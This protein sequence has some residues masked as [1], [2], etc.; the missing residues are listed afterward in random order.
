MSRKTNNHMQSVQPGAPTDRSADRSDRYFRR[1]SALESVPFYQTLRL[2]LILCV[3]AGVL[4]WM[5]SDTARRY[6]AT[7]KG[8]PL[9]MSIYGGYEQYQMWREIL[10]GF[11]KKTHVRVRLE[12]LPGSRYESKI[13]Q[14]LVANV[15]PDVIMFQD[16]PFPKFVDTG[17]FED[18]TPWLKTPGQ[19]VNLDDLWETAVDSFDRYEG[20]GSRR[21]RRMYG[22]PIFGGCNLI[23]YNK[24]CFEKCGVRLGK[25][26]GPGGLVRSPDGKGWILDDELWTIADFTRLCQMLTLDV[27]KDQ[28]ID[29]FGFSIPSFVYWL[30]FHWAMG[31]RVLNDKLTRTAFLGP[32]CEA[33]LQLYQD[34]RY[35]YHVAPTA[36]E[37][38]T[39]GEG[40]GFFTGLVAMFDSGPW[41]MPFLNTVGVKYDVLNMPRGFAG[42]ARVTR[43]SWDS[44]VMFSGSKKKG[45]AWQLMRFI[46]TLEA[47]EIV[48]KYQRSIPALKEATRS[49]EERNPTVSASKFV[50]ATAEYARMQPITGDWQLM[51]RLWVQATD[52][53]QN[54]DPN[55]RLTPQ[56][57]IGEFLSD[58]EF[59]DKYPPTD[60]RA[61]QRYREIYER[62]RQGKG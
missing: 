33:S 16:E 22:L 39:M 15:A 32:E 54:P 20:E 61:A 34:L 52:D 14:M 43:V 41:S 58:K 5:F 42:G 62:H 3:V 17:K 25:L 40:V 56:E 12:Y 13:Q 44:V 21:S 30:P 35:K 53:L 11:E 28:R 6:S 29:Q 38:G 47:Q 49:F 27:D 24:D 51:S 50:E 18:L 45:Q 60:F 4:Y 36:A 7:G 1:V 31:A 9:R 19:E 37:L 57:A 23:F 2:L 10:D 8:I 55:S 46:L 59:M 26:P 48:N